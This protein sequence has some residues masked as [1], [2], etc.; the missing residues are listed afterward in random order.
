MSKDQYDLCIYVKSFFNIDIDIFYRTMVLKGVTLGV[1]IVFWYRSVP[2][3][4]PNAGQKCKKV[5]HNLN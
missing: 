4:L 2:C 1:L 3:T 5:W